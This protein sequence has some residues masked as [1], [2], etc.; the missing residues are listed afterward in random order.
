[1]EAAVAELLEEGE[2]A[3][4]VWRS[5]R[6]Y[7]ARRDAMA[8][9]LHAM[10]GTLLT[11]RVPNGGLTLW[12]RAQVRSLRGWVNRAAEAGVL[13]RTGADFTFDGEATPYVRFGFAAP[14]EAESKDALRRMRRA[15]TQGAPSAS[16][17]PARAARTRP[18]S[19]SP[20]PS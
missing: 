7:R 20:D 16:A 9:T 5:R 19:R 11:F 18:T 2:I 8:E 14:T 4:H 12:A 17:S 1:M 13:L 6:I 10:F 15:L 3:R